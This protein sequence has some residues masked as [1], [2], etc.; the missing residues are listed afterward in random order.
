MSST[1]APT[2]APTP[3]PADPVPHLEASPGKVVV[4][5]FGGH[6][7]VDEALQRS[8]AQ[9]VVT[10]LRAGVHP[11]VVHGGGPRISSLLA[12]L[13]LEVRFTAGLRVT[14]P[15]V[16]DVVRMVL[17][18][19]V[20]R[21]IVGLINAHGPLAVGLTGEDAHT[22]TAVRRPAWVDGDPVDIGLVGE[23]V[24]VDPRLILALLSRG[25][26]PVVSPLA[27]G[28]GGEVYNV[29]ADLAAAALAGA[30]GAERLIVL[31]DVAGLHADWPAGGEVI[32]RLTAAELDALLPGL[33]GGMAP[34]MEGCLRAVRAGVRAARVIDGRVPGAVLREGFRDRGG[35]GTTVF[36]DRADD[37][38]EDADRPGGRRRSQ[39]PAQHP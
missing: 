5:K 24:R 27:R 1:S 8:F 29:N 6:A 3:P 12:R 15:E 11:V 30:L 2:A 20:Q 21:E 10:L 7:M 38:G 16:L 19:Q 32:E 39:G 14:T 4:V 22:L 18:G 34:K 25:R 26:V 28:T 9:D 17:A 37:P 13:D 33:T 23:V 35:A 36:P 31:T